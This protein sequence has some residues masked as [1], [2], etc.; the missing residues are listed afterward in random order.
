MATSAYVDSRR[1][2]FP[3]IGLLRMLP[4]VRLSQSQKRCDRNRKIPNHHVQPH[5]GNSHSRCCFQRSGSQPKN[6]G[7]FSHK[8]ATGKNPF[9]EPPKVIPDKPKL[10]HV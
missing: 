8:Q 10:L 2:F 1:P 9:P 5:D 3:G 7:P 4:E 6:V